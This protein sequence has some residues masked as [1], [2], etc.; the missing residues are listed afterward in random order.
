MCQ[1]PNELAERHVPTAAQRRSET[2]ASDRRTLVN[3]EQLD[4][5]HRNRFLDSNFLI[6]CSNSIYCTLSLEAENDP[7][8][9]ISPETR[10]VFNDSVEEIFNFKDGG[11]ENLQREL[12]SF[13]NKLTFLIVK[14]CSCHAD[15]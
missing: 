14:S 4:K 3:A 7:N 15:L 5:K 10:S 1:S 6:S 2:S 8:L 12:W 11:G 13:R 9:V